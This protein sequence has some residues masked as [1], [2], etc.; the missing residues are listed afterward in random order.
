MCQLIRPLL[1]KILLEEEKDKVKRR[2]PIRPRVVTGVNQELVL[3][4]V[5]GEAAMKIAVDF[6]EEV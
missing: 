1:C 4:T 6:V 2:H 5:L 3:D